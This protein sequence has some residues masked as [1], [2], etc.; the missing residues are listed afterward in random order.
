MYRR[1]DRSNIVFSITLLE[2][3]GRMIKFGDGEVTYLKR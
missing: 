2:G 3:P 1:S